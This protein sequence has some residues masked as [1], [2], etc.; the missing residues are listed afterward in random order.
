M[1]LVMIRNRSVPPGPVIPFL[2]YE[3]V[4]H[5]IEWLCGAFG[6]SERLRTPAEP[7]G[8][9]HLAQLNAGEGSVMLRTLPPGGASRPGRPPQSILVRIED[10]DAHCKCARDYGAR[11]VGE[12]RSAEFGERQYSVEDLAGNY[13]TFSQTIADVDPHDW[14][15]EVKNLA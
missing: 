5:A 8:S 7:D 11:I 13:W 3:D 6:F 2:Y 9:I 12:P 10:A 14:G 15:A 4:P 1:L